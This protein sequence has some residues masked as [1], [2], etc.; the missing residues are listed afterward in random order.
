[1]TVPPGPI[2]VVGGSLAGLNAAEALLEAAEVRS[3]TLFDA[4]RRAPYD[5]PP[6]S[7]ELLLGQWNPE[8]CALPALS[9]ARLTRRRGVRV[10]G[11]DPGRLALTF[12]DGSAERFDGGVVI[13]TGTV[14]RTLPGA[15]IPGVHVLRTL[16]DALSL[17]ADIS[18][19][20]RGHVVIAGGGFIGTEVAAACSLRGHQ[21]TILEAQP[22]PF[23]RTLGA[24]V[25]AALVAPLLARGVRLVTRAAV[26]SVSGTDRVKAVTLE[27]GTMIPAGIVVLGLGVEPA[28]DWLAGAGIALDGG[29]HCDSTLSAGHRIVAAGDVARWP[30]R[31]FGEFRR[32]EHWDNA[33]RQGT[34]AG[35]RL[36][37]DHGLAPVRDFVSVPWVW[38][39]LL[40]H[41]VQVVGSTAG[42]D[43]AVIAHGSLPAQEFVALYRRGDQLTAAL[44]MNQPK[45][46]TRYRRL[47]AQ[48]VSWETALSGLSVPGGHPA[49]SAG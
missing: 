39:D 2:A 8:R 13:A 34:H 15:R 46:I 42:F 27:D 16:D 43:E 18:S 45:L 32:I 17:R 48:P 22:E 28:T 5:R 1:M 37:A 4:E 49:R 21:V 41:K 47:L 44:A 30:N 24:E 23:E 20:H 9:D 26:A 12:A 7:K 25:G 11:L 35:Q 33:I 19:R 31:R 14:P 10:T 29:V 38:S 6:L 3:V 40:D 36:L